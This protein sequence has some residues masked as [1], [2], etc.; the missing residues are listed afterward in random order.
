[1]DPTIRRAKPPKKVQLSRLML[2]TK[3]MREVRLSRVHFVLSLGV[4]TQI[5]RLVNVLNFQRVTLS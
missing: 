3:E 4:Q 5:T 2:V 1:M